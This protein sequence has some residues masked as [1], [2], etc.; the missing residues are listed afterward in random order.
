MTPFLLIL[1][2]CSPSSDPATSV[3]A[4]GLDCEAVAAAASAAAPRM[5]ADADRVGVA[6]LIE[7]NYAAIYALALRAANGTTSADDRAA[8]ASE[9]M[10]RLAEAETLAAER[11]D[12][13]PAAL[14][15]AGL[16]FSSPESA[17][18][19]L[20]ALGDALTRASAAVAVEEAAFESASPSAEIADS[21]ASCG[22]ALPEL[23][24]AE[25][26]DAGLND[27][28]ATN[29]ADTQALVEAIREADTQVEALVQGMRELAV[30]SSSETLG[31]TARARI[32]N[33]F[34]RHVAQ[35]D[36]VANATEA[37]G[38]F[39]T[40]GQPSRLRALTTLGDPATDSLTVEL[41]NLTASALGVDSA[42]LDLSCSSGASSAISALD[43]AIG[44]IAATD[45]RLDALAAVLELEAARLAG[46]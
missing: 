28:L 20:G 31:D 3:T 10:A 13:G 16:G 44:Q 36:G 43:T 6:R 45:A 41:P 24:P 15:L 2:S 40:V 7:S 27:A 17:A 1:A 23:A 25:D 19:T 4:A 37:N 29:V 14:G 8:A 12:L 35:V 46:E 39:P 26:A 22:V 42:A 32:Q 30:A 18:A 34:L 5:E 33:D 11:F 9:A 38:I 21:A